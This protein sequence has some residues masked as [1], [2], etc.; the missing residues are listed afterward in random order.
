MSIDAADT[1]V[2]R[3]PPQ[4]RPAAG[5]EQ[6]GA[7]RRWSAVIIGT[8][9]AGIGMA[10][11]LKRQGVEDFVVLEKADTVGGVWRDN[12]Y[13][14]AACDVPSHLYSF[15][16]APNPD[17]TRAFATQA[18]IHAYLERCA[19]DLDVRRHV[20]FG[21]E[22]LGADF[23]E[24][25]ACWTVRTADGG[26]LTA[27][28]LISAV[29]QLS[30]P[31]IPVLKGQ[32]NLRIPAFHSAHWDHSIPLAGKRIGVI[33]T[34]AS[35][36]QFVPKIAADAASV[37]VFQRSAAYIMPKP[38]RPY[39]EREKRRFRA[40]PSAMRL[41]R[42]GIYLRY[43][44]RAL[45]FTRFKGLMEIAAARPFRRMLAREVADPRTRDKLRPD[46]PVG[47]KRL[48]LSDDYLAT[49]ARPN[50]DLVTD[51]IAR[52]TATG[53]ET[54]DGRSHDVDVLIYGTGFAATEFLSP[55]TIRGRQ[56]IA[57][58]DAWRDGAS[59]YLGMAVPGFP[60]FFMLYGPNTN[61]GHNSIVYMIESQIAHVLRCRTRMQATGAETIEV[62]GDAF[63]RHDRHVQDRLAR[64]VW[65]G[66]KS[67][68]VDARGRNTTNWPGFTLS[69]RALTRL[70]SLDAY[71]FQ[72]RSA[73][74]GAVTL[75]PPSGI[76]ERAT[77]QSLRLFLRIA[78]RPLIGP[79]FPAAVQRGVVALLS[80]LMPGV[81]GVTRR[82]AD[83]NGLRIEVIAPRERSAIR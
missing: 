8:G 52:L 58:N 62:A 9:F 34:G 28:L 75:L 43:E 24:A 17:W 59:A 65:A 20:R 72:S 26:I 2:R 25:E 15:S 6:R 36:I 51:R 46:Y 64:T 55:M 68:Y 67:W 23:D 14:G 47:C 73:R 77:A 29:G 35:A 12:T 80:G 57:L 41:H 10:A 81:K 5:E 40:M 78:F 42:L 7:G 71:T 53:V 48:L 50:V 13:P 31:A 69:Y 76:V 22:V 38:D 66:C 56:G 74:S 1:M 19:D 32:E 45:A 16:F 11:G 44:S 33:G 82:S 83:V 18:E 3:P 4:A 79:P 54:V 60:N 70:R 61:L 63:R 27:D 30:R 39:T 37:S 21:T 49:M